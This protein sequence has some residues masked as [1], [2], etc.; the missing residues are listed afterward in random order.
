MEFAD[1]AAHDGYNDHPGHL[2]FVRNRWMPEVEA[3]LEIDY[4]LY[5]RQPVAR[6][7]PVEGS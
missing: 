1:Q 2:A 6:P 7:R 3:F 4:P 5:G